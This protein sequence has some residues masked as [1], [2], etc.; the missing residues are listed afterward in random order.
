[1]V[2]PWQ[3]H[4]GYKTSLHH[5][6]Y[7]MCKKIITCLCNLSFFIYLISI[8]CSLSL[9]FMISPSHFPKVVGILYLSVHNPLAFLPV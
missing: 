4:V 2:W 7:L 3:V 8:Q 6:V 1:M 9:V 5:L